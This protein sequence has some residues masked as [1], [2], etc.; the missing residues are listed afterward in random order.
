M[1]Q[2]LNTDFPTTEKKILYHY[3]C[4]GQVEIQICNEVD[5]KSLQEAINIERMVCVGG[6]YLILDAD[7]HYW[8]AANFYKGKYHIYNEYD[9][10]EQILAGL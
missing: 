5:T 2:P 1:K 4:N 10:L 9:D 7:T 3:S 6:T 8:L